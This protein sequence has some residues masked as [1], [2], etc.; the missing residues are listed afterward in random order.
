MR[1]NSRKRAS[2]LTAGRRTEHLNV[3]RSCEAAEFV[4]GRYGF[5]VSAGRRQVGEFRGQCLFLDPGNF[6]GWQR[7]FRETGI[8]S[9]GFKTMKLTLVEGEKVEVGTYSLC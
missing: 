4:P 2:F 5:P 3:L 7:E 8:A 9:L 6:R 1:G